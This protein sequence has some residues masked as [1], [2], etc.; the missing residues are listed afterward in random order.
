M[1]SVE[2]IFREVVGSN[3]KPLTVLAVGSMEPEVD[4]VLQELEGRNGTGLFRTMRIR[5]V[6]ASQT[7]I[8]QLGGK[9]SL[10]LI[11]EHAAS[12]KTAEKLRNIF[13]RKV[14]MVLVR[15]GDN[16]LHMDLDETKI[17]GAIVF[18]TAVELGHQ[19]LDV[20]YDIG[21]SAKPDPFSS[22]KPAQQVW[23]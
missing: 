8:M 7:E 18:H 5:D 22:K 23:H 9:V 12:G 14:I 13:G 21:M 17:H 20:L 4:R 16:K 15:P 2:R 19:I 3:M 6:P 1:P 10:V 11:P